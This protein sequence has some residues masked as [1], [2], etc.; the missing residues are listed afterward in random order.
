MSAVE[1]ISSESKLLQKQLSDYPEFKIRS[2]ALEQDRLR[3][4]HYYEKLKFHRLSKIKIV[5][6]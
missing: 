4:I 6:E 5:K 2:N 1:K 3:L